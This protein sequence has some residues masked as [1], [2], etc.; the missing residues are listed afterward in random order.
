MERIS[1]KRCP[2]LT[3]DQFINMVTRIEQGNLRKEEKE[4]IASLLIGTD[5]VLSDQFYEQF[6]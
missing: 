3:I 1:D 5:Y 6:K 2:I 4:I